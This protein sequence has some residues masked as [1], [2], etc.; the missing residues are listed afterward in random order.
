MQKQVVVGWGII[1]QKLVGCISLRHIISK[2]S[3]MLH[4]GLMCYNHITIQIFMLS[5]IHSNN[6]FI[7]KNDSSSYHYYRVIVEL[8]RKNHNI[9]KIKMKKKL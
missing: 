3:F 4:I 1:K 7:D 2:W 5:F 8:Q 6:Q 9:K